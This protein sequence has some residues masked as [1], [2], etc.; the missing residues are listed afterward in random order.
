MAWA[1]TAMRNRLIPVKKPGLPGFTICSGD[2]VPPSQI[3]PGA[4]AAQK[5]WFMRPRHQARACEMEDR[6]LLAGSVV[7]MVSAPPTGWTCREK[8][9]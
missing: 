1:A 8:A 2:A 6:A 3:C 7:D 4:Q 9:D 5:F